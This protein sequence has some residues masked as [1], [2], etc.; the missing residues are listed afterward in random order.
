ARTTLELAQGS[1]GEVEIVEHGRLPRL[2]CDSAR[3][4]K[5]SAR[6]EQQPT[7]PPG[8]LLRQ[9]GVADRRQPPPAQARLPAQRPLAPD[10]RVV[11]KGCECKTLRPPP[12]GARGAH[13]SERAPGAQRIGTKVQ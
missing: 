10:D 13:G 4:A 7:P 5:K 8:V 9:A 12:A 3:L 2:N 6:S 11:A 1:D